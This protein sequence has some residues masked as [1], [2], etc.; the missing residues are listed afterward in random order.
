MRLWHKINIPSIDIS[1]ASDNLL[2]IFKRF[3]WKKRLQHIHHTVYN[4]HSEWFLYWNFSQCRRP[5][6]ICI[7]NWHFARTWFR[8]ISLCFS[9]NSVSYSVLIR[10]YGLQSGHNQVCTVYN[11]EW[12]QMKQNKNEICGRTVEVEKTNKQTTASSQR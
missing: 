9:C 8:S 10:F 4:I 5:R 3:I 1:I 7:W 12:V 6:S 11:C 2:W